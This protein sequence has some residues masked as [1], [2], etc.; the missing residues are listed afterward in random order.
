MWNYTLV[1]TLSGAFCGITVDSIIYPL[2]TIKTCVFGAPV[3]CRRHQAK[4]GMVTVKSYRHLFKGL[5][6]ILMGSV[7]ASAIYWAIYEKTKK[8][9]KS[10]TNDRPELYTVCEMGAAMVAE[11][12]ASTFRNPFEVTKQFIQVRGYSNPLKAILEIS[13]VLDWNPLS[14]PEARTACTVLWMGSHDHA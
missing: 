2:D 12:F 3:M 9:L 14:S 7:P 10:S 5:G 13:Q 6:T 1:N 11:S 4:V 8:A